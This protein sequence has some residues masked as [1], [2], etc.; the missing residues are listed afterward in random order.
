MA[1]WR[2]AT[3]AELDE[4]RARTIPLTCLASLSG[5]PQLVIPAS[6]RG[7]APLGVS[8]LGA[9]GADARLVGFAER[10]A[11]ILDR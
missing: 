2:D 4:L 8:F 10:C 3:G 11:E 9:R 6:E 1:P 5:M 7:E